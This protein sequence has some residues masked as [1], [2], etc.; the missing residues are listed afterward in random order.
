MFAQVEYTDGRGLAVDQGRS[1]GRTVKVTAAT[2]STFE[3]PWLYLLVA[4]AAAGA[5]AAVVLARRRGAE[6][7]EIFV[8]YRD[9]TLLA[10]R[11][12]T[13][14][15]DKDEDVLTAMFTAVQQFISE[16]FDFGENRDVRGLAI[17]DHS[18][19]IQRGQY[20]YIAAIFKGTA[21]PA[22]RSR[23]AAVVKDIEEAY[24]EPLA[25]WGGNM[26]AIKGLKDRL[27]VLLKA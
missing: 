19:E 1:E 21:T 9:G 12:K 3:V 27:K 24:R 11:S 5:A 14:T 20:I 2:R 8:V 26:D 4:L 23:L 13:L 15:P 18:V 25:N 17:G 6:I 22:L 16:S 10:H 7:E